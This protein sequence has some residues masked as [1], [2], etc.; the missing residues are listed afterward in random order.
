MGS[1]CL[2]FKGR[3]VHS[4][5]S[6]RG[7]IGLVFAFFALAAAVAV[8]LGMAGT[9]DAYEDSLEKELQKSLADSRAA[10]LAASGKIASGAS[11]ADEISRLKTLA[12]NIRITTLLLEERFRIAEEKAKSLGSKAADRQQAMTESY[13]NAVAEYLT[14]VDGIAVD[15]SQG[16]VASSKE[17]QDIIGRLRTL[18]DRILPK[19]KLPIIGSLPYK[20]LNLPSREPSASPEVAP[21][22]HGGNKTVSSEDTANTPEAPAS[23]EIASLAQSL[24]WNPVSIYEYVK[25]NVE[26][27]WYWGCMKGAEETLSQKSGNDC[28]Q[29]TLLAALLR[30][31]GYPTRYVRGTIEFLPNID[32]V[33]N[34]TGIDDPMKIAEFFQKAG[35]PYKPVIAGGGIA[36]FQIEHVWVESQIPYSNYRGAIIDEHGKTWL[37]LDTS[38][39]VKGYE[40]GTAKDIF[41]LS[42]VSGKLSALRDEYLSQLQ[43]QTPLEYLKSVIDRELGTENSA[44]TYD[45][46]L[47]TRSLKPEVMNILP[48][49]MQFKEIRITNEYTTIPEELKHKVRFV[50]A[51]TGNRELLNRELTVM[52]VSNKQV[53]ISYEPETVEDQEII[54]SY[55]SL[56][57][58]PAYL[59]RLR[60]VLKVNGERIAVGTDGLPMGSEYELS[61]EVKGAVA[62]SQFAVT[63]KISNSMITGNITAIGIVAGLSTKDTKESE[64]KTAED[65]L[66]E[67]ASN[68]IDRWNKSEDELASLLH[69][70]VA[71]PLPTVATI[72]GM[73]DVTYVLDM[74]HGFTWKGVYFDADLRTTEA[75][76][77]A[78]FGV[79]SEGEREKLFMKI[80]S[81][82]GSVLEHRL[83]EDD[84]KVES[85]ST[86]KL[87]QLASAQ[88]S[89]LSGRYFTIDGSN[90][91]TVLPTLDVAD[92][93]KED[94]RNSVNQNFVVRMP[95]AY[96]VPLTTYS[97]KDWTGIGYIKENPESGESGW[98]L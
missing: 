80:S 92:N 73:I 7:R 58:T 76:R 19:K 54:N 62:G 16:P 52:E 23:K 10:V 27:E 38:I 56:D 46:F 77:S 87:I 91:N 93:I 3:S 79:G 59:V 72:G 33:K 36:N 66:A 22:Y 6:R 5:A 43:T 30:A 51:S 13:R 71:R 74:P 97:Y 88:Q 48:A 12:D 53:I 26:T 95:S 32:R 65:I 14:I 47:R 15:S 8:C 81:L 11:I 18:L 21:A 78:E 25:N 37:G 34:L 35:I 89:A 98:M 69:V 42:A 75:V 2:A 68:Y 84:F 90:I 4:N 50:A 55:G 20:H 70:A 57:N 44:L 61:I 86:A 24:N 63:E 45:D 28:D 49:G 94:I 85:I 64:S 41:E 67:E 96:N 17:I 82:Q 1:D 40:Y 83:F 29:A 31:S 9:A 39:K 60:P